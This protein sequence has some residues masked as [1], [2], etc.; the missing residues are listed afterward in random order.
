MAKKRFAGEDIL[1]LIRK[2]EVHIHG[3]MY[4]ARTCRRPGV[5][6]K[7]YFGW[8]KKFSDTSQTQLSEMKSLHKEN[9]RR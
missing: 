9:G 4:T 1:K 3:D 6:G 2:I 5:S 7:A 8:R